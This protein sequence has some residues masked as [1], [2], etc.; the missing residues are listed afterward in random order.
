MNTKPKYLKDVVVT[1]LMEEKSVGSILLPETAQR[2]HVQKAKVLALGGKCRYKDDLKPGDTVL[3]STYVGNRTQ[4]GGRN[5][6]VF[7]G[8][9]LLA[10]CL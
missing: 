5:V 1:E 4:W 2:Y 3:V 10:I 9:D 7:D 6:I 8:E